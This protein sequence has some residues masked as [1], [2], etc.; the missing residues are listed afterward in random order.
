ASVPLE[1]LWPGQGNSIPN[2]EEY[3][4]SIQGEQ[5]QGERPEPDMTAAVHFLDVGHGDAVLMES[6]GEYAL[7]DAGPSE[8]IDNLM[9]YLA[10]LE[11]DSL[12]YLIM[13]HPHEDHIG[14]MQT[15][16]EY[17]PVEQVLL[18]DFDKGPYPTTSTFEKL[19]DAMLEKELPTS[20]M[21]TGEEYPLGNGSIEVLQDGVEHDGNFNLLSPML[22][23][24][25]GD[26]RFLATGDAEKA[27]EKAAL[28]SGV[29]LWAT[30]YK[31]AH[32]G[33]STSNTP[34]FLEE[35]NPWLTVIPCGK[36]NI[37]GHPHREV[38]EDLEALGSGILR[39]DV[40][41]FI[42]VTPDGEGGL[43]ASTTTPREEPQSEPQTQAA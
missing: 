4:S 41:G 31:A 38:L 34:E 13:S 22:L 8:G 32:H 6:G 36:D 35:V 21:R 2:L 16:V 17:V 20:T 37:Y 5:Q 10:Y 15:V 28:E 11:I 7:L 12:K 39:T 43:Q 23:F 24:E 1:D 3:F 29:S 42:R 40:D 18:P 9:S 25:A 27:N 33:S 26:M 14:G 19:L 30:L